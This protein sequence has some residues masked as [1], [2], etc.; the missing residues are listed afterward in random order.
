MWWLSLQPNN[1][2]NAHLRGQV[3]TEFM[4]YTAVFMFMA[5]AAFVVVS[6]VQRSELPLQQN[7]VAKETGEGFVTTF[8][9][10]VKGGNGF[11]YQYPFPKT[12]FGIPYSIDMTNINH[13]NSTILLSWTGPYG[14]FS[15]QYDLPKYDYEVSGTCLSG[16]VLKSDQCTNVLLFTND[17]K[18]LTINQN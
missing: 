5:I 13:Q 6:D 14:E 12:I 9:L 1:Q 8:I 11:Q 7:S 18:K 17:G 4:L 10:A 16:S 15:Y 3:A 2:K